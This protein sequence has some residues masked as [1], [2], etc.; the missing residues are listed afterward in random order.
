MLPACIAVVLIL[1][2]QDFYG[3]FGKTRYGILEKKYQVYIDGVNTTWLKLQH[4]HSNK[5]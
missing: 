2:L 3:T 1:S 5:K 4:D